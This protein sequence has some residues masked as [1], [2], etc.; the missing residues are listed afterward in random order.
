MKAA[1][2]QRLARFRREEDGGLIILSLLLFMCMVVVSG[3]AVDMMRFETQRTIN[4]ATLDRAV[5]AAGSRSQELDPKDVVIDYFEKAGREPPRREDIIV[6]NEY[7][8]GAT[9]ADGNAIQGEL[10]SRRVSASNQVVVP[11]IFADLW[12]FSDVDRFT[13]AAS[14][15]ARESIQNV[16]ISLVLDNSGSMRGRKLDNLKDAAGQFFDAV[17]IPERQQRLIDTNQT[18]GIVSVSIIPYHHTVVV[19]EALLERL[20]ADGRTVQIPEENRPAYPG[21]LE[22]YPTDQ[23]YS[24]CIRFGDGRNGSTDQFDTTALFPRSNVPGDP[25]PT[26]LR[27]LGHFDVG[28]DNSG[29]DRPPMSARECFDNEVDGNG[30]VLVNSEGEPTDPGRTAILVHGT[31]P[32]A[33]KN[34]VNGLV[35]NRRT[36]IENGVKWGAA[37]LDPAMRPA[38]ADMIDDG[39]LPGIVRDRPNEFDEDE[40]IK[41]MV[42]MTDGENTSQEDLKSQYDNGPT[43]IWYSE[44]AWRDPVTGRGFRDPDLPNDRRMTELDGFFVEMPN[45]SPDRRWFRP[46]RLGNVSNDN[47]YYSEDFSDFTSLRCGDGNRNPARY[48]RD[49]GG[50]RVSGFPANDCIDPDDPAYGEPIFEQMH[51]VELYHRFA[52]RDLADMFRYADNTVR[53]QHRNAHQTYRNANQADDALERICDAAKEDGRIAVFAIAFEAPQRGRTAMQNCATTIDNHYFEVNGQ[54]VTLS[55]A[56][57]EIAGQI[58][59]LRLTQ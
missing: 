39:E 25:T 42:V 21:A 11:T 7:I 40:T 50:S 33:L 23:T 35:A 52:T 59:A 10:V 34:H 37:L 53:N 51:Y 2:A 14:S 43:R 9:D 48:Q 16:E 58:S 44:R 4:Q 22:A 3:L 31:D 57:L 30:D 55:G 6:E 45:N 38:L 28:N 5:L 12:G 27:R 56:L 15:E 1:I 54:D 49:A 36:A 24:T 47:R 20:D 8:G 17:I 19:G 13:S 26:R 18:E 41:V 32:Q 46:G 29:R